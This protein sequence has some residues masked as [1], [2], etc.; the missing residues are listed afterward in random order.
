M[1]SGYFSVLYCNKQRTQPITDYREFKTKCF[2]FSSVLMFNTSLMFNLW[3][4]SNVATN[5]HVA[6]KFN[7]VEDEFFFPQGDAKIHVLLN[8]FLIVLELNIEI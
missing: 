3:V 2:F 8:P 7:S 4:K 5:I 1:T 6:I